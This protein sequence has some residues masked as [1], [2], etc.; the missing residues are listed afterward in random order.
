MVSQLILQAL[1]TPSY[2]S[3]PYGEWCSRGLEHSLWITKPSAGPHLQAKGDIALRMDLYCSPNKSHVLCKGSAWWYYSEQ[4]FMD[5]ATLVKGEIRY[6]R[7]QY[8]NIKSIILIDLLHLGSENRNGVT[9][10]GIF[11]FMNQLHDLRLLPWTPWLS[12]SRWLKISDIVLQESFQQFLKDSEEGIIWSYF[13]LFRFFKNP[14]LMKNIE[15]QSVPKVLVH[16]YTLI[17]SKV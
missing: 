12:F 14:F 9:A 10:Q 8:K 1:K 11:S 16:F 5:W 6:V 4:R 2:A 15:I 17:T 7:H 13:S 3:L